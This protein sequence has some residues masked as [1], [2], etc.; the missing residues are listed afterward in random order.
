M[1]Y[2]PSYKTIIE[3]IVLKALHAGHSLDHIQRNVLYFENKAP[4]WHLKK[5]GEATADQEKKLFWIDR[6]LWRHLC[7]E[8]IY[9]LGNASTTKVEDHLKTALENKMDAKEKGGRVAS[10]TMQQ[11]DG[12]GDNINKD[13]LPKPDDAAG[14][15]QQGSKA[16]KK[17]E[18]PPLKS[19]ADDAIE[20]VEAKAERSTD[21]P[22]KSNNRQS[23]TEPPA[24]Y[25]DTPRDRMRRRKDRES[26]LMDESIWSAPPSSQSQ[27]EAKAPKPDPKAEVQDNTERVPSEV[28][29]EKS[30]VEEKSGDEENAGVE[31]KSGNEET[32]LHKSLEESRQASK[33]H[34][35]ITKEQDEIAESHTVPSTTYASVNLPGIPE[36][37][38]GPVKTDGNTTIQEKNEQ[39]QKFESI[40]WIGF[41]EMGDQNSELLAKV[42]ASKPD[43][44]KG[45][46][47]IPGTCIE[48][49]ERL[50][51][52]AGDS[53]VYQTMVSKLPMSD[54]EK[55]FL[56]VDLESVE[57]WRLK[58]QRL[59]DFPHKENGAMSATGINNNVIA[60]MSSD[61][62]IK[63]PRGLVANEHPTSSKYPQSPPGKPISPRLATKRRE[64]LESLAAE[65]SRPFCNDTGATTPQ[66]ITPP[67][68]E[69]PKTKGIVTSGLQYSGPL[70]LDLSL[71]IEELRRQVQMSQ[72]HG[73]GDNRLA[74]VRSGTK[75]ENDGKK[76]ELVNYATN[77]TKGNTS[78]KEEPKG[79][80]QTWSRSTF[81][82]STIGEN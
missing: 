69:D 68:I 60:W 46:I 33:N 7:A 6:C 18:T 50:Y 30:G 82:F 17:S 67:A 42:V 13:T 27:T 25:A 81:I 61:L 55:C 10:A 56:F 5:K 53:T 38:G 36:D 78:V 66:V 8:I 4:I 57:A 34:A 45:A 20:E 79:K 70:L 73:A 16:G 23:G 49:L 37:I 71:L 80:K 35:D 40:V 2:H 77:G 72:K 41:S 15:G 26:Q 21:K 11:T 74:E 32:N 1:D 24:Q 65:C 51:N 58:A 47:Q 29:G 63:V 39:P 52:I 22:E 75:I 44:V 64:D 3:N 9:G 31:D 54:C 12:A 28:S 19:W 14:K 48:M 76:P 59:L 62:E 43:L